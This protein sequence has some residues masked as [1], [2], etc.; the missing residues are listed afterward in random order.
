[1]L[2]PTPYQLGETVKIT[3]GKFKGLI[4]KILQYAEGEAHVVIGIG[5]LGCAR[6]KI[7]AKLLTRI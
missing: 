3:D 6:L 7:D 1:M 4:G 2:T 5:L